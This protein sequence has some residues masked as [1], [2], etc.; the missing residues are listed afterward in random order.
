MNTPML[1]ASD[2][3]G[4]SPMS[5]SAPPKK[6]VVRGPFDKEKMAVLDE[7]E[8]I[9]HAAQSAPYADL[10]KQKYAIAPASVAAL[11]AKI[12]ECEGLFGAARTAGLGSQTQTDAK[13]AARE[14]IIEAID[15]FRTG[16]RLSLKTEADLQSFGVGVL[17]DRNEANLAQLAQTILDNPVSPTLRGITPDEVTAL[18]SALNNWKAASQSQTDQTASSQGDRARANELFNEIEVQTR[19]IK[20]AIDGKFSYKKP[21]STEARKLFHLPLNRP[22]A[23]KMG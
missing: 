4:A 1:F 10:L 18:Q 9:A 21:D 14:A 7:C 2:S 11:L 12:A 3:P 22:F 15:E 5:A 13:N 6:K 17:L 20:I 8:D 16:A 23:P 19:D